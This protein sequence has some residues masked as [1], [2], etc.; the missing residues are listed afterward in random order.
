MNK[1]IL[2]FVFVLVLFA[3]LSFY[4]YKDYNATKNKFSTELIDQKENIIVNKLLLNDTMFNI[5]KNDRVLALYSSLFKRNIFKKAIKKVKTITKP[6]TIVLP[7]LEPIKK[8]IKPVLVEE[9]EENFYY[10][11]QVV[12]AGKVAYVVERESDKK[13]F[14][15]HKGDK[16]KDFIVLDTNDKRVVISDYNENIKILKKTLKTDIV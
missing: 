10:R 12:L 16:L 2:F 6:K 5:V 7:K 14:F 1:S 9:V 15:V 3:L 4:S 13:T 11:G 8:D